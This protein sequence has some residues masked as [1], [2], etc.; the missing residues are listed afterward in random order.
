MRLSEIEDVDM[1]IYADSIAQISLYEAEITYGDLFEG[2]DLNL[3]HIDSDIPE[4][5]VSGVSLSNFTRALTA[6]GNAPILLADNE[7]LLTC[8]Y[9]STLQYIDSFLQSCTE[10][11]LNGTILQPGGKKPLGETVL[12]TS[13]GNNDRGTFIVPD[14]VPA[15]L[16]QDVSIL[17]V[18]Y[19]PGI[20]TDDLL[21]MMIPIALECEI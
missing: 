15:S 5:G 13:V 18:L 2:P 3:W 8:N 17:L 20:H 21:H 7:F 9:K 1:G 6:Q 19:T 4:V 12:M 14:H 16:P 10:I 11:D